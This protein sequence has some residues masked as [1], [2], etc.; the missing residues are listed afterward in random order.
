M[1]TEIKN[2][3][4][5]NAKRLAYEKLIDMGKMSDKDK[6]EL[7]KKNDEHVDNVLKCFG[8]KITSNF[9]GSY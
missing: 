7:K 3:Y 4:I 9:P 6:E 5:K 1:D 8:I 2:A